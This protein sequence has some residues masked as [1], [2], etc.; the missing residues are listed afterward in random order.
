[1]PRSKRWRRTCAAIC[2]GEP[3]HARAQSL[4]YRTRKYLRRHALGLA[5]GV[6]A[7]PAC[8]R[9]RWPSCRGRRSKAV[10][11]ATRAQAMQDF[12][13]GLFE[14]S[15]DASSDDEGLDVR[16][17]LDAGVSRADTELATQPQARAELIGLIATLRS[18]LGD[19]AQALE[20]LDRQQD[21]CRRWTANAPANLL[22][23]SAALRG[24]SLR[25]LG[26]NQECLK[27]LGPML[28]HA[29]ERGRRLSAAGG[30]V[31]VATGPLP[32]GP[33]RPA[34]ARD[35][36]GQALQLR[37]A[38]AAATALTAE[39]ESDLAMLQL[40]DGRPTPPC[41]A[42]ATRWRI[43][44]TTAANRTRSAQKSG[45][46]LGAAF[47]A[48]DNAAEAEAAYRQALDIALGR[49]GASHPRT[50]AIQTAAGRRVLDQ[51]RQAG[52]SRAVA[53]AAGAGR[54][55]RALGRQQPATRRPRKP[56]RHGGAGARPAW[57]KPR[58]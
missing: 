20:L 45:R 4:G 42:C 18:G 17:L 25:E 49:F 9:W 50:G 10:Q 29:Q 32:R 46:G 38:H 44:A 8:W 5:A 1:M 36:F 7:S 14:N 6:H 53:A 41:A 30:G 21:V 26:R 51:Q 55:R 11:E 23:D 35:L 22:L 12:V 56:A 47:K 48:Q 34:V 3:V 16:A 24:H 27:T 40:A 31:P 58:P 28:A 15:G 54:H 13:V 2:D 39:S 19:D 37:K 33:R 57:P 52:R 43:C